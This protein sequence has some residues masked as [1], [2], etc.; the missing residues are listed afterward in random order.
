MTCVNSGRALC[1]VQYLLYAYIKGK[2]STSKRT[3]TSEAA[4]EMG[5]DTH[6]FTV[7]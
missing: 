7:P 3:R 1:T 2:A 5:G 6:I 4:H